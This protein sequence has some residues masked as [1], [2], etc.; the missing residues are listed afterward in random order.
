MTYST[1]GHFIVHAYRKTG[2][3]R[4]STGVRCKRL[5]QWYYSSN[6]III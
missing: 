4:F 1:T 3:E 5:L 2:G 6:D